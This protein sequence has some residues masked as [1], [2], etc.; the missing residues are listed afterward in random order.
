MDITL[1]HK[2]PG[3]EV[4][5]SM[6]YCF[7]TGAM[8]VWRPAAEPVIM[9]AKYLEPF[10]G[11]VRVKSGVATTESAALSRKRKA[12]LFLSR[13][14]RGEKTLDYSGKF[15]FDARFDVFTNIG[16]ILENV[17]TRVLL[18]K[19]F[20]SE[21]FQKDIE[22]HVVL[23]S[24]VPKYSMTM[25]VYRLLG[26][27]LIFTDDNVRGEI[28]T[29]PEHRVFSIR[30]QFFGFDFPGYKEKTPERIFIPRR[31]SRSLIN[32]DEVTKF[33]EERGFKTLYFEDL[34]IDDE[35][36]IARNAKEV[37][38]VHG[39]A[40][41]NFILNRV[42]MRDDAEPGS[43]LKLIELMSPSWNFYENRYMTNA[44]NGKWCCV[45]GQITPQML[46]ALD[47]AKITPDARKSPF[48]DPFK[49]DCGTIQ[50]ALDYLGMGK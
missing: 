22:I 27:P 1:K 45:R 49:V 35:W 46:K 24:R 10:E 33:M 3:L 25:E 17:A 50:M 12:Q 41:S 47:F 37:V 48:K 7:P 5:S 32:N 34:A 11:E 2:V 42:G 40:S 38:V 21:H 30:P 43:G 9:P 36:S 23:G 28:V 18:A 31:G 6:M 29:C 8:D 39:A 44:L 19:K 20:L 14:I 4:A 15:I 16:H 26:F 13:A